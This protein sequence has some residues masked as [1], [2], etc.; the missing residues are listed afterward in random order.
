MAGVLRE[1][2]YAVESP[3]AKNGPQAVPRRRRSRLESQGWTLLPPGEEPR[4]GKRPPSV[5]GQEDV[6]RERIDH[7][8]PGGGAGR[9]A[10]DENDPVQTG[11]M[12]TTPN[13][14]NVH[15]VGYDIDGQFLYV[16]FLGY[17]RGAKRGPDGRGA[18][19]GP[20]PLYRYSP[21]TP[22]EFRSLLFMRDKPGEWIWDHL[23]VRGTWSG[24]YK[25][26][27]LIGVTGDDS[28]EG[29]AAAESVT[30]KME[31]WF[32]KRQVTTMT[33]GCRRRRWKRWRLRRHRG[34]R[35]I[36]GVRMK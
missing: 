30:G 14:S 7:P 18:C 35:L 29:H 4:R 28:P 1:F 9:T 23:R 27:E 6:N 31:E 19:G 26:Y 3:A 21:C 32:V 11:E 24:H 5:F 22:E 34:V 20:G 15:S 8:F 2:G 12:V 13:S 36:V 16:R 33:A 17:V 25:N 10:I